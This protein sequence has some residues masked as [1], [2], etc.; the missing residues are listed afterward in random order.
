MVFAEG[1][2]STVAVVN[3]RKRTEAA[4]RL[5]FLGPTFIHTNPETLRKIGAFRWKSFSWRLKQTPNRAQLPDQEAGAEGRRQK[6]EGK[7]QKAERRG[8]SG[9]YANLREF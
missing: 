2:A 3:N 4:E 6:A 9:D 7:K 8:M 1:S 5:N